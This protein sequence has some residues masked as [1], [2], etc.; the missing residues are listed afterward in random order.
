MAV[1]YRPYAPDQDLL[2]P[3]SLQDWLPEGHLAYFIADVVSRL[4]LAAFHQRYAEGGP[5]NQ[6]FD[7]GMMVRVLL[8]AYA[9]GTFSSRRIARKLE[10]DVAYRVLAAG[11][12]PAHR[13]I[14]DFRQQNLKA[15]EALF[16]QVVRIARE[17]GAKRLGTLAVDGTKL[18][19]NASKRK[20]MSYG[21]MREEE[22][23]LKREIAELTGRAVAQDASEDR[24]YGAEARGDE[25]PDELRRREQRLGAI[26]A[27]QERLRARQ[28]AADREQGRKP[29]DERKGKG[30]KRFARD[31]GAPAEKAQDNFTDPESRIMKTG[32][33]FQQ[34]YN[35]QAAVEAGSQ[36]I[37]AAE[38]NNCAADNGQLIPVLEAAQ[39]VTGRRPAAVLA[40]AGYRSEENFATLA[41]RRIKAYIALGREGKAAPSAAAPP[42]PATQR[43][44]ARMVSPAGREVYRRRKAI[45]EPV[46]GW[47]KRILGFRQ[48]S[49]R[50]EVRA[51][52]EWRMVCTAVNLKR[53]HRLRPA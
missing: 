9:T 51:R 35:A 6:P 47:I 12:A 40:D 28:A 17:A 50:G 39:A 30:R 22:Q 48:F 18:R 21:R 42:S 38:L 8:Y 11:N 23:R 24:E 1:S 32:D 37:V 10:E 15:F 49:L 44:L 4:D 13:T 5:R 19:A 36:I 45:V 34:C 20:A 16:A 27:A 3:P 7:P 41:K 31:F 25:L 29:E 43:M 14:A 46:F 53:M 2:L 33:G 26:A 52:A